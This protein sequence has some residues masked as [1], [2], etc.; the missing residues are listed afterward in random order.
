[1]IGAGALAAMGD[2]RRKGLLILATT[3][4]Y[5]L[6]LI[7][8]SRSSMFA[9]S[10]VLIMGVGMAAAMFDAMQWVLLQ[11]NVPDRFRGRAIGGWVFAIGFGWIGHLMLGAVAE[12]IG[13][14]WTLTASGAAVLAAA[15]VA[16]AVSPRLRHA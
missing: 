1:M 7:V 16:I 5:G 4:G 3:L 11:A 10:L 12:Q 13:V 8:F 9:V 14:Q 2:Y 15:A 6:A